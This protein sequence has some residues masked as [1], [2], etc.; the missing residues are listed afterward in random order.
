MDI[1]K[2]LATVT[3]E[4]KKCEK[5]FSRDPDSV[6]LLA[7]SKKQSIEKIQEAIDAGQLAFGESYLQEALSKILFFKNHSLVWHFIGPIQSNKIK[8]IAEHFSWVQ[9][10]SDINT[11]T[12]LNACRP[13]HLPPLN[14]CLQ[15]N[16]SGEQT[17]S[18]IT[19]SSL[20][21]LAEQVALLT[22]LT[23]RGL[24]TIPAPVTSFAEQREAFHSLRLIFDNLKEKHPHIDTLSMG[25]SNDLA[26][27]I[28][29]GSTMIRIG[30]KIFGER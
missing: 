21:L 20:F 13:E 22:R 12:R 8:K 2:N 5:Q 25:M 4:I 18:G 17:K 30:T 15:V 1:K 26:A 3:Q 24:M 29:E 16:I 23:L 9:S 7:V 6:S 27:A 28:A 19:P 11:A 10:V 14:I